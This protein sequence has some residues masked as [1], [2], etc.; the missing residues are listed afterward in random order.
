VSPS[1]SGRP[2]HRQAR[3]PVEILA[4][5]RP[6]PPD[7][8]SGPVKGVLRSDRGRDRVRSCAWACR[9]ASGRANLAARDAHASAN[10]IGGL[11]LSLHA[12]TR[13]GCR[14]SQAQE[15]PGQAPARRRRRPGAVVGPAPSSA[16]LPSGQ[17]GDGGG[18][19]S[20][21]MGLVIDGDQPVDAD[22][23]IDLRRCQ[24]GVPEQLLHAPEVSAAFQ[25]VGGGC[26]AQPVRPGV[27]D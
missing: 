10:Q 1:F 16:R 17:G 26:V 13:P 6:S 14:A 8:S 23:G 19:S 12:R 27:G 20:P 7:C 24:R 4:P 25:E 15:G 2:A 18:L 5:V 21:R 11:A 9:A 22:V 3:L